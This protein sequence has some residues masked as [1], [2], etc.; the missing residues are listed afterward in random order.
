VIPAWLERAEHAAWPLVA[1][2]CSSTTGAFRQVVRWGASHTGLPAI[3]VAALAI[4]LAWRV[5][6]RT[7]HVVFELAVAFGLLLAATKL[8]WIRW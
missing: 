3:V 6:R 7:W 8:G 2:W 5:A 1:T 4:V